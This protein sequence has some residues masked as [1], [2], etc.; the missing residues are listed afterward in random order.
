MVL[1][2]ML[3]A[4]AWATPGPKAVVQK[5][6]DAVIDILKSREDATAMSDQDRQAISHAVEGNFDFREMARR[7]LSRGWKKINPAQRL[8]FTGVFREL[9][10]YSYGSRLAN[11]S[12]QS[13][14]Y[15][16]VKK[17]KHSRVSVKTEIIDTNRRIPV[18]YSLYKSKTGWRVY[19]IVVE[20]VSLVGTYR[21]SFKTAL[22]KKGF[23]GLMQNMRKKVERLKNASR[24]AK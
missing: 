11:F 16:E 5:T 22:K 21:S 13:V 24:K 19:N 3:P 7:S 20:G 10:E 9:L 15:G 2:L 4:F 6:V 12:G 23:D 18:Q 1:V 14:E 17:K 8:E